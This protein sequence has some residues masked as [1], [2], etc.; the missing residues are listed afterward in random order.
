VVVLA[1]GGV[2][3]AQALTGDGSGDNSAGSAE[4][5]AAV[6]VPVVQSGTAY[7]TTAFEEQVRSAIAPASTEVDT[8]PLTAAVGS[9]QP[10]IRITPMPDWLAAMDLAGCLEAVDPATDPLL[11]DAASYDSEAALVIGYLAT[12]GQLDVYAVGAD[13]SPA[14]VQLLRYITIALT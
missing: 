7:T 3:G 9:P 6:V 1:V 10:Q 11:V 5:E 14:D 13:C 12:P 8:S 2:L 4:T